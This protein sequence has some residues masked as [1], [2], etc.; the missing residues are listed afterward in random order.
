[1]EDWLFFPFRIGRGDSTDYFYI[2]ITSENL[3]VF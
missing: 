2:T 3:K 1:M